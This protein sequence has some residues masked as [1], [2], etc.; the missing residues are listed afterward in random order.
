[1]IAL[2]ER[3]LDEMDNDQTT[4]LVWFDCSEPEQALNRVWSEWP[5]QLE[6]IWPLDVGDLF[7]VR[8]ARH[9]CDLGKN[10]IEFTVTDTR[11][12]REEWPGALPF[13]K[14]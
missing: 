4:L 14:E 6:I 12:T 8:L 10:P 2:N 3:L 7:G 13:P 11:V 5:Y 1:L 9:T